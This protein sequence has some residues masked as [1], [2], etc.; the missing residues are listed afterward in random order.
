MSLID[1]TFTKNRAVDAKVMMDV[2]EYHSVAFTMEFKESLNEKSPYQY[3]FK[4]SVEYSTLFEIGSTYFQYD[5]VQ[6]RIENEKEAA[7]K[8]KR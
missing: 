4:F 2:L 5:Q 1:C 6:K 8:K 7:Q 3:I